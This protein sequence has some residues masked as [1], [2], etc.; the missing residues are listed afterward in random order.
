M[1]G[2]TLS[3]DI[4]E[5]TKQGHEQL[6]E[7]N[8]EN[9][10]EAFEKAVEC[11][12]ELK[13]GYTQRACHFNLGACYV[14]RGDAKKGIEHLRKAL[15]P[16]K[17][18]DG[19]ANY[20]DLQYNLGI[21]YDTLG[22]LE[23]AVECYEIAVSDYKSQQNKEMEGETLV[24]LG[25]DCS[26]LGQAERAA[27]FYKDAA[28]IYHENGDKNSELLILA[29]RAALLAELNDIENCAQVLRQVIE[30]CQEVN[31]NVLKGKMIIKFDSNCGPFTRFGV[32]MSIAINQNSYLK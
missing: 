16:H 10:S 22:Q 17:E 14:A 9:A 11:A 26:A 27:V 5:S 19:N 1:A 2:N 24:K 18:T 28:I 12:E 32:N 25:V 21:A 8:L 20:A 6:K 15:P 30:L 3:E 31:D 23:N 29:S 13:D 4:E 7:G